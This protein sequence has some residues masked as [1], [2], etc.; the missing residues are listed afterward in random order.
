MDLFNKYKTSE[1][2]ESE[3]SIY[4]VGDAIFHVARQ[5]GENKHYSELFQKHFEPYSEQLR[6]GQIEESFAKKLLIEVFAN[7]CIKGWEN[8]EYKG[9][10]LE[11]NEENAIMLMTELPDFYKE[12]SEFSQVIDNYRAVLEKK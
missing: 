3:G 12:L 10:K 6:N 8:V 4:K 1:K 2:L 9:E 7:G 11:Y 5:G